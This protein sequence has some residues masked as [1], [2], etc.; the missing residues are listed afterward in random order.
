VVVAAELKAWVQVTED[1]IVPPK[2]SRKNH[3]DKSALWFKVT[4]PHGGKYSKDYILKTLMDKVAPTEFIPPSY[5]VRGTNSSC[6]VDDYKVAEKLASVNKKITTTEG[7]QLLVKVRPE[8]PHVVIDSTTKEKIKAVM[9][10]RYNVSSKVLDL[11]RFHTDPDLTGNYAVALFRPSMM[12]AVLNIIV[13]NARDLAALH[14]SDN[15][16]YSLGNFTELSIKLPKL[17]A[18]HIGRNKIQDMNQLDCLEGLLLE[19]LVLDGNPLC[20]KYK[21]HNI[22]VTDVKKRFP[23]VLKLDGVDLSTP[24]LADVNKDLQIQT[25]EGNYSHSEEGLSFV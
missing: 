2:F 14:L 4:I 16:L 24:I 17:K 15:K 11:S 20:S 22:Y 23:K 9:A 1:Q 19:D 3:L 10:L 6:F 5:Q 13:E 7:F 21:N 8:L 12:L 25:I 18:L